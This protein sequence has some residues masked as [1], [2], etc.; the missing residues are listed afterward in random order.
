LD[1]AA[2][3]RRVKA[4]IDD[5]LDDWLAGEGVPQS[6]D[7]IEE[8]ALRLRQRLGEVAAQEMADAQAEEGEPAEADH[9]TVACS[10]GRV[11]RYKGHRSRSVVTMAGVLTIVRSYFYC[12]LCDQ[13][14]CP[15]DVLLS[16]DA[17]AFTM[18]VQ[19]EV[20]RLSATLP[21]VPAMQVLSELAGVSVCAKQA[22]RLSEEMGVRALT[23][24]ETQRVA[25][26]EGSESTRKALFP[27]LATRWRAPDVL[28]L[29]AD[30]V[31]TPMTDGYRET[32]VGLARSVTKGGKP[33]GPTR[34]TS[35]LGDA[36]TFGEHWYALALAA[37]LE[38]AK[39]VVVLGDGAAWIWNQADW[40][41]PGAI[42]ILD[43]FHATEHLWETAR[44]AYGE[45]A[46]CACAWVKAREDE[47]FNGRWDSLMRAM[48]ALATSFP[49]AAEAVRL[50]IGYLEN[51][52]CRMD[53]AQYKK[54]GL[55]IGSGAA[56][57]G[58]KRVVTQRLKGSGMRW[59]DRGAQTIA[60]L[61]CLVLSNTWH[62]F[63]QNCSN[64]HCQRTLSLATI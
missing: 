53:Y 35:H 29:E 9:H 13:G 44:A 1:K 54:M 64:P 23:Y 37:G 4:R 30:G 25:A 5:L 56:E 2:V 50:N 26:L 22:Q 45:E 51:N 58:C 63:T 34:Y 52:R 19:Q 59:K 41:F 33:R 46:S 7:E 57:S 39:R 18:R 49:Q 47:L 43:W 21:Y 17:S 32:K 61:R 38:S 42:Q 27:S 36:E 31:H 11:A 3:R 28:Y 10:C 6:I 55:S 48:R 60:A 14:V 20:A 40:H 15:A 62:Q 8:A 16:L 12:R 24:R